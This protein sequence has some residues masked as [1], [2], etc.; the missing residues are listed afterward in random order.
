M[1]TAN[2]IDRQFFPAS[3]LH[4]LLPIALAIAAFTV[5]TPRAE[6]A[7]LDQIAMGRPVVQTIGRDPAT[8]APVEEV[9]VVARVIPDPET[10]TTDSG[11]KLLNDYVHDAARKA[12]FAAD[13]T[14]PDD[15]TCY[16]KAIQ[17]AKPQ[18]AALIAHA[19]STASG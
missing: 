9:T 12:C 19:K 17:A 2:P 1:T 11:I 15:G 14:Q 13:P 6:A 4:T 16:H 18:V 5:M 3:A 7:Q 8:N 10:L